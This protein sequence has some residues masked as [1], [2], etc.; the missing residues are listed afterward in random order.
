SIECTFGSLKTRGFDLERTG[1]TQPARLERLFGLVILAWVGCLGI[2]VWLAEQRPIK[3]KAH[4]R[5]AVSLVRYGAE[6]LTNALR[7]RLDALKEMLAILISP[8][9]AP[10]T[11]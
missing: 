4:G 1:I 9:P 7:W 11:V 3:V 5:K 6:S 2:G 8:F 10:G